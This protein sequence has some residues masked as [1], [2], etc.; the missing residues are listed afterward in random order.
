MGPGKSAAACAK[1]RGRHKWSEMNGV[2]RMGTTDPKPKERVD[3]LSKRDV[4][5]SQGQK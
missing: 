1:V 2:V 3:C 4:P 5:D